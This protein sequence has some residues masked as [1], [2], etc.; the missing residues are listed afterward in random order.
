MKDLTIQPGTMLYRQVI[1]QKDQVVSY[2]L[3][4][5]VTVKLEEIN[6]PMLNDG[7]FF[8]VTG[9]GP[10]GKFVQGRLQLSMTKKE[11]IVFTKKALK[12][13]TFW[14]VLPGNN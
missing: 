13:P 14:R 10:D 8:L 5:L 12:A 2:E 11:R 6:E 3:M 9:M 1:D 7:Y 4:M